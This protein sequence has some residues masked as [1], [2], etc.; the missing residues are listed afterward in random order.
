VN[1]F[2]GMLL[3]YE[4]GESPS[5]PPY[6]GYN[7]LTPILVEPFLKVHKNLRYKTEMESENAF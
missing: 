5:T 7:K 2:C 3:A 6:L 4:I 1:S